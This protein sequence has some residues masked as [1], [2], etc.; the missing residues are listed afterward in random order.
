MS[1]SDSLRLQAAR[2]DPTCQRAA[3]S[4]NRQID[5]GTNRTAVP[6]RLAEAT[7]HHVISHLAQ[8]GEA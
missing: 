5:H 6:M 1:A 2:L 3:A 8:T 7:G 4:M